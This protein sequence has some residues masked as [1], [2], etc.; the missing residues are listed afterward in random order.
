M[1]F[2]V[3]LGKLG[4]KYNPTSPD[5]NQALNKFCLVFLLVLIGVNLLYYAVMVITIVC[6]M[7]RQIYRLMKGTLLSSRAT[8]YDEEIDLIK[9]LIKPYGDLRN[10]FPMV[11]HDC[12]ICLSNFEVEDPCVILPGCEHCFHFTCIEE[13]LKTNSSCPYCRRNIRLG[14]MRS[15]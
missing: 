4:E 6:Y 14:I 1:I 8:L 3:S 15:G 5:A 9:S 2:M 10:T 11:S 13:W 12:S 7:C